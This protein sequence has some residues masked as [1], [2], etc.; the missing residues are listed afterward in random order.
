MSEDVLVTAAEV[1]RLAGVGRAAVSNWRRRYADFP[2]PAQGTAASPR[3]RLAEVERWL[4]EQGKLRERSPKD[5]LL[6][7][8]DTGRDETELFALLAGIAARIADPHSP[9]RLPD[10]VST[11]LQELAEASG[12]D[13]L[14]ELCEHFFG[15]QQRQHLVTPPELAALM[16]ELVAPAATVFDPACGTG[17]LLQEAAKRGA[18]TVVGQ[19]LNESLA[20]FAQARLS[21]H[22][23]VC[24]TVGDS[25]RADGFP[26]IRAD[27][28]LC[29]PPFAVREWGYE[30]LSLDPRWEYGLPPK[31]ESE[32]A[33]LQHCLA[34]V[35]P[36]GL[37]VMLLTAGVA[38]RRPGRAIR[39]ALL[40]RGSVRAVIALP[41]GVLMTTAAP[42]HLWV[43]RAPDASG[44]EPV[45]L[46]D[47][48][49]HEP[50]RRG[51]VDWPAL[52]ASVLE[53]WRDFSAT[54]TVT[55]IPGRQ[56]V[57]EPIDLLDEDVDL[58]PGRR[59]PL[60][61]PRFDVAE[62]AASRDQVVERLG[63]LG[64]LLPDV[65]AGGG[66]E[67]VTTTL[68]DLAGAGALSLYQSPGRMELDE[69]AAGPLV[70]T[71]RDVASGEAPTLRLAQLPA[72][73]PIELRPGDIVVSLLAA[74]DGR[75][76]PRVIT[77]DG[78]LLGPNLHLLRVNTQRLDVEFVAGQLGTALAARATSSTVSGI[79]RLDVRRVEIPV[80]DLATQRRIGERF[81]LLREFRDSLRA[82]SEDGR[83]LADALADG[84]ATGVLS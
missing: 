8:L 37:V 48:T 4:R 29:N 25:L 11:A 61:T 14:E 3:F 81:R 51:R 84:L 9:V 7:A 2:E 53:P 59:L 27:A 1:A 69:N 64:E 58:T 56:R 19:E 35:R 18:T 17:R 70:L 47:A 34:H 41:G 50:K 78:L 60:P 79:H 66:G 80:L 71:G 74:G 10:E 76:R 43:L 13:L 42:L 52:T 77:D 44:A 72:Q 24:V 62:L 12:P 15:L 40:R 75:P 45:L 16:A 57:V 67:R 26:S 73:E 31:S 33:W 63:R 30:E 54:G 36:G 21:L 55:E 38:F 83:E 68:G 46:V 23:K 32:L 22:A 39:Q 5:I 65:R 49:H 82:V 20:A 6:R 28:V